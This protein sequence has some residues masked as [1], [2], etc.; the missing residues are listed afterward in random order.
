MSAYIELSIT[1]RDSQLKELLIALL[2]EAGA[3][4][5]EEEKNLLKAFIATENYSAEIFRQIL[6]QN[7]V[8][9]TVSTIEETNWNAA[10]E[11]GFAPVKVGRFCTIRAAF[12]EA[13]NDVQYDIIITPK[14]SFG[15]GHHATTHMM[16]AA[17]EKLDL[18]EKT[19]FDFGTGTG[20]LAI[21]AEK[22]G[23]AQV[24]AIDNDQWS[25]ENAMENF[26]ANNCHK[27]L[28]FNHEVMN[29]N[30]VYDIILANINRNIILQHLASIKQHLAASGVVLLSGLLT[31][32]KP[33]IL[34][35]AHKQQ[36]ELKQEFEMNGWI[37]LLMVNR[38]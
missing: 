34:D 38:Q 2:T 32:D 33:L 9:Y 25:M 16:I 7:G 14:M 24:T 4:G 20:V 5:F 22:M 13:D 10:W 15:T 17:M 23:A 1:A 31:G 29:E 3:D 18:Y 8:E 21:L 27:V 6:Q 36:L 11:S 30:V 37:C 35:E 26:N 28:L 19:V 12:H